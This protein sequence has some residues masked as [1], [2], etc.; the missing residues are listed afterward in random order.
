MALPLAADVIECTELSSTVLPY[1]SQLFD[2]PQH[3]LGSY[4]D[5]EALKD[6]YLATNPLVTAFAFSLFVSPLFLLA[7]EVN[8]N[9]SQ[10]D[11][12][13]SI[14]PSI[15]NAHYVVYAHLAS[16]PTQRLHNLLAISTIWS[17]SGNSP[18]LGITTDES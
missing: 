1:V 18:G 4:N 12:F 3:I 15:Y 9:Y 13:W 14:L 2:L 6:L 5:P 8:K 7:S 10:V 11:R 16:L 17:V